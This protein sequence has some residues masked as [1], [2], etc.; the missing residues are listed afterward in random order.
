[1]PAQYTVTEADGIA[2]IRLTRMFD[3]ATAAQDLSVLAATVSSPLRLYELA[4]EWNPSTEEIR[5]LAALAGKFIKI[6]N[7]KL[8][9]VA[10]TALRFGL[11][12]MYAAFR[13][14]N[15][16][17]PEMRVFRTRARAQA[18]L[19]TFKLPDKNP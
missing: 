9:V 15:P 8:A 19:E 12:R 4:E 1:M 10:P 13:E 11:V 17:I 7:S 14:A 16:D 5:D 3:S 18:W 6:P 2:H